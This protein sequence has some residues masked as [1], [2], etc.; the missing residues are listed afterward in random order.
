MDYR[1]H[2]KKVLVSAE[3]LE[4]IVETLAEQISRDYADKNLLL[5]CILKGSIIFT[6]ELMQRLTIPSQVDFMK[7][8][9]YGSGTTAGVLKVNLDLKRDDLDTTDVLIIEDCIDTGRTLGGLSKYL[10]GKGCRSV[11]T[12]A[13]LD[14]PAR[15]EISFTPDYVGKEIPNEFVVGYGLDYDEDYRALPFVGVLKDEYLN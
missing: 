8:S 11:K 3:E 2:I 6:G 14:K 9:S 13:L 7:V 10:K 1:D 5:V 12:C 4:Q 15:R